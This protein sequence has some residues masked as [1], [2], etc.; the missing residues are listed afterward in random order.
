M[1][2][3]MTRT[4]R[5]KLWEW[6]KRMEEEKGFTLKESIEMFNSFDANFQ[7]KIIRNYWY[8]NETDREGNVLTINRPLLPKK[9]GD[10]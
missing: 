10:Q 4:Q 3:K 5:D 2:K 6:I 8:Q 1:H 7:H 9:R